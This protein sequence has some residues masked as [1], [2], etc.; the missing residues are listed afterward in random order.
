[1]DDETE[2]ANGV[3]KL[4]YADS[5]AAINSYLS[6][7]GV[8]ELCSSPVRKEERQ[9]ANDGREMKRKEEAGE[10]S[11]GTVYGGAFSWPPC[12]FSWKMN[13]T[14]GSINISTQLPTKCVYLCEY[15]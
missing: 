9:W 13:Q 15:A 8:W 7:T 6:R 3:G 1:M 11:G 14:A 5:C 2:A 12:F 4:T 10:Q